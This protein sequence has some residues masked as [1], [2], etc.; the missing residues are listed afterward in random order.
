MKIFN[1][2][3]F[4]RSNNDTQ[5]YSAIIPKGEKERFLS[6]ASQYAYKGFMDGKPEY[7]D[8]LQKVFLFDDAQ[9]LQ[10]Q[11][12]QAFLE[13]LRTSNIKQLIRLS[14]ESRKSICVYG[15]EAYYCCCWENWKNAMMQ[16]HH[17]REKFS[18]LTDDQYVSVLCM[19]TFNSNGYYRQMCLKELKNCGLK[20]HSEVY[21]MEISPLSF[22]LLRVNDWVSEIRN[23]A[24]AL[25]IEEILHCDVGNLLLMMPSLEKIR[26]SHRR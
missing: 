5:G 1:F 20:L 23:L 26:N 16:A 24:K 22:Y 19:G 14:E 3:K 10:W 13:K 11:V 12:A 15:E 6:Y 4:I 18:Y 2:E 17:Y 21:G 9:H 25:T 7:A 8:E